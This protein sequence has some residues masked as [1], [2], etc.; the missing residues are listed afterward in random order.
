MPSTHLCNI[1]KACK[2]AAL[3]GKARYLHFHPHQTLTCMTSRRPPHQ[4]LPSVK[5]ELLQA[6]A[7]AQTLAHSAC[8]TCMHA[9]K[10]T[11][12]YPVYPKGCISRIKPS[13]SRH[14]GLT[15]NKQ[16]SLQAV[17]QPNERYAAL[18]LP[19]LTAVTEHSACASGICHCSEPSDHAPCQ[20]PPGLDHG[21]CSRSSRAL[22]KYKG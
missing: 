17:H 22:R 7:W 20:L 10:P 19:M 3:S 4:G 5:R 2:D 6:P 15:A 1:K 16:L 11:S 13:V 14:H 18:P 8:K 9:K 21:Q 12:M